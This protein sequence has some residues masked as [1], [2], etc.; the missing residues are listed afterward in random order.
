[1]AHSLPAYELPAQPL[2]GTDV[3]AYVLALLAMLFARQALRDREPGMLA[4]AFSMALFGFWWAT[5]RW[6]LPE[7]PTITKPQWLLLPAVAMV[8]LQLGLVRYLDIPARTRRWLVPLLLLFPCLGLA[9]VTLAFFVPLPRMGASPTLTLGFVATGLMALW[10]ARRDMGAGHGAIGLALLA[11]P[12]FSGVLLLTG[13]DVVYIRYLAVLPLLLFGLVLLSVSLRR[14][15][16]ALQSEVQRRAIAEAELARVN[17]SLESSVARRTADLQDMVAGLEGFTRNVSHDLRGPLG[18]IA[19]VARLA[20]AALARGDTAAATRML[21]AIATQAESA[22]QLV[23]ALLALARVSDAPLRPEPVNLAVLAQE[24]AQTLPAADGTIEIEALPTV[25][26][27]PALLR[28]VLANLLGNAVKFTRQRQDD[29]HIRI[30]AE[31]TPQAVTVSV[32]DNG[33]GFDSGAA[34]RLFQPF[35]R[36]HGNEVEGHGVGLSIVRRAVERM[37]GSVS[38]QGQPGQGATFRFSLPLTPA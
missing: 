2:W 22:T 19:G 21:S 17:Q 10:S 18:G 35:Q 7:G 25:Q 5:S 3:A 11:V 38:A 4:L 24:V 30:S 20:E 12:V 37:G 14:R 29:A 8:L 27:D 9:T 13:V 31:L 32:Q 33:A 34:Q 6:H 1:M 28:A 36:L 26:A 15:H 16:R 23:T